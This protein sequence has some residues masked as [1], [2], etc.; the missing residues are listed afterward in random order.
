MQSEIQTYMKNGYPMQTAIQ[1]TV[2][3]FKQTI[4]EVQR[5]L[6]ANKA[7]A[8]LTNAKT[9]A[10]IDKLKSEATENLASVDKMKADTARA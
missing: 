7:K 3:K 2:D 4:P 9:Q 5:L 10:E 1:M 6:A 8:T